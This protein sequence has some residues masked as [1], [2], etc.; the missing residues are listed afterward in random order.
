MP[1]MVD[2]ARSVLADGNDRRWSVRGGVPTLE[3]GNDQIA[4][5]A[6]HLQATHGPGGRGEGGSPASGALAPPGRPFG[7]G[8]VSGEDEQPFGAEPGGGVRNQEQ[9]ASCPSAASS[10]PAGSAARRPGSSQ[11]QGC[12]FFWFFSLGRQRK[13]RLPARGRRHSGDAGASGSAFPRWS[14]G[15][16]KSPGGPGSYR[17]RMGPEGGGRRAARHPGRRPRREGGS[18]QGGSPGKK[19]S[20]LA[21]SR[22]AGCGTGNKGQAVRAQRVLA[23]PV[24]RPVDRGRLSGRAALSFGSFLWAGKEKNAARRGDEAKSGR[25]SVRVGVPTLERGNDQGLKGSTA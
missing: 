5:G 25:W 14:V 24:P 12:P 15:T 1:A 11:R 8:R 13:E 21:L 20:P 18:G 6:G 2:W 19:N 10:C 7:A 9:G 17:Q 4:R 23:P 3:R 22:A 16:I